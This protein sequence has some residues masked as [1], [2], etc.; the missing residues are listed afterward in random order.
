MIC[1]SL[2]R[3]PFIAVLLVRRFQAERSDEASGYIATVNDVQT[4]FNQLAAVVKDPSFKDVQ[5]GL[6]AALLDSQ[7]F[8][9][10]AHGVHIPFERLNAGQYSENLASANPATRNFVVAAA[11]EAINTM[12]RVQSS[13]TSNRVVESQVQAAQRMLPIPGEDLSMASQK[14]DS[15]QQQIDP[16]ERLV[17]RMPN[18]ALI[19]RTGTNSSKS[20]DGGRWLRGAPAC[21]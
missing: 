13:G 16:I 9:V 17:P 1:Y 20:K 14:M 4:K 2:C 18:A 21:P 6:A 5:P 19:P 15:V 10:S 7:G 3:V 8:A 11:R 12:G